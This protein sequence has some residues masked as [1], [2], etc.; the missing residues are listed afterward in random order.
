MD[1]GGNRTAKVCLLVVDIQGERRLIGNFLEVNI[2]DKI[3][4]LMSCEPKIVS[5]V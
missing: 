4:I 5:V 2:Y 1:F 3:I